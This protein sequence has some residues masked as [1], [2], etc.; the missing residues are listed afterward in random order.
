MCVVVGTLL[1]AAVAG[2]LAAPV[3]AHALSA[4]PAD[5][6]GGSDATWTHSSDGMTAMTGFLPEALGFKFGLGLTV[7]ES[8]RT[9][10]WLPLSS[11]QAAYRTG[12][13]R[14]R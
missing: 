1:V 4:V 6:I 13:R 2:S 9:T 3:P 12:R 7:F 5:H 11:R 10:E 8:G 14:P